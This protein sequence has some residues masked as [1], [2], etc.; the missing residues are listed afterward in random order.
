MMCYCSL[1]LLILCI[2]IQCNVGLGQQNGDIRLMSSISINQGRVEVY[3][4]GIWGTVCDD[5]FDINE[6]NVICRQLGFEN[7]AEKATHRAS[8]GQG[9]GQI[10]MDGL[11]CTGTEDAL[12]KCK[13][14]GMGIHDC[15]HREDAG[16]VCKLNINEPSSHKL[17]D[18]RLICPP[19][20][21][22]PNGK[23]NPCFERKGCPNLSDPI[24][25]P[26]VLGIVQVNIDNKW[27][28]ISSEG[29]SLTEAKVVCGQLGYP[30]T[31]R[32]PHLSEIWPTRR[33]HFCYNNIACN[34]PGAAFRRRLR[35]TVLDNIQ[36]VGSESN[37]TECYYK[38]ATL[39]PSKNLNENVATVQ[40]IYDE[41]K[42]D[43]CIDENDNTTEVRGHIHVYFEA[44]WMCV[45]MTRVVWVVK[46]V[47]TKLYTLYYINRLFGSEQELYHGLEEL[48]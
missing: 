10:W 24:N 17:S 36:C 8:F 47:K 6:A 12:Y 35:K 32:I 9:T 4:S 23:C 15:A 7:G 38:R 37:I 11:Q 40:C 30:Y 28:P 16:V 2:T 43:Q 41:V 22:N 26:G 25:V 1:G 39:Q 27:Y 42:S 46:Y 45:I 19:S 21:R 48:R 14:N 13:S 44:G 31:S 34:N 29:W 5:Q 18:V 20:S 3:H 33:H